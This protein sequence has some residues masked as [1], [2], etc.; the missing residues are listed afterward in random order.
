MANIS[1]PR[2]NNRITVIAGVSSVDGITPTLIYVDP[3]THR[4]LVDNSGTGGGVT[5][6]AAFGE[7]PIT[8]AVTIS[9]GTGITLNQV[10]QNVEINS[11]GGGGTPGGLD[12]QIQYNNAGSFGGALLSYNNSDPTSAIFYTSDGVGSDDGI[13][14]SLT[15]GNGGMTSGIGG[16]LS[17]Q[18]G[19]A[20]GGDSDGG[21]ISIVSGAKTGTG[22]EGSLYIESR[23]EFILNQ[24][25]GIFKLQNNGTFF[26]N[27]DTTNLI[28]D[29]NFAFPDQSGTLA[30]T[31]D[32]TGYVTS[33]S[34]TANRITSTGGTTP[35]IDIS[36][37]YIG[38]ASIT[39]LGTITTGVWQGTKIGLAFGGTNADLSATGGASQVLRQSSSGAAITVSQLAASDLS[40]GTTGSG[41]VVLAG[42]PTITTAVLGSSTA[43]TQTFGTNNTTLATTEFVQAA[44]TGTTVLAA[45][46]LATTAALPASTYSNGASGVGAT[47][48]EVG[49]G[50]LSIDGVTPSVG[51]RVLIKNQVSTFQNGIYTVT[52]VGSA[53]V[54]FVLTRSTDFDQSAEVNLGDTLF[55][56]AGSTLAGT[57]W[58]Q[59]GT[60]NPVMGTD[61]ITFAQTAGPGSYTAGN[62][63]TL[64]GTSFSID[65]SVTVD[66]NTVQTL[67]NKTIAAGSNTITGLTNANLSGT[68]GITN[69]N[70]ANS[71]ITIGSTN[72]ALGATSTT[73]AGLSSVTSTSFVGNLTGNADTIT[74]A[75]EATDTTCFIGFYTAA[76]G[77]LGGK[78]NALLTYNSN[79]NFF[80]IGATPDTVL[81]VASQT[82]I[83]TAVSGST[84]HFIGLDANPLRVTFDTHNN[85]SSSGTAFMFRRSRGTGGTPLAVSS[86]DVLASLNAR[87]YGTSQY[88]AASTGVLSWK[89]NQAFT[90]TA[91]GTYL[92]IDTT[93]DNSVTAGEVARFTG[94]GLTLGV[95]GTLGGILTLSG[96]STGTGIIQV[97]A[98][99]GAGIIFQIPSSN[100]SSGQF[101]QTNGS[102]VTSWQPVPGTILW[103]AVTVNASFT[104]NTGTLANKGTLLS[105]ALPTTSAVG[106]VV[107]IAGMNAGLWKIT[108]AAS[109]QIHF[110]NQNTTNGTGGS[111][112]SVL[113]Y[114]SI[115][116]VCSVANLEWV[117]INSVG[118]ITVT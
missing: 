78:T 7:T 22:D 66:K 113:T 14:Y 102:G 88:A 13:N 85:S 110:G 6:F 45:A 39:T 84:S 25:D 76:T 42:S 99:A 50:A 86:G 32:L 69:A 51:N 21:S 72:I 82:S 53:G 64:T 118:N 56:S 4:L 90:N 59:N 57:T 73:L 41:A 11:T 26:A 95:T 54:A 5:S 100:G 101:L 114:D 75:N 87:G 98:A 20:Q 2:D 48:T 77:S 97:A 116:L 49:L 109:Q 93:P 35:V 37:T 65:T 89:A 23:G 58:T 103:T 79:T 10:G 108:Q 3:I 94:T 80:G 40:N 29:Q 27:L 38:Q 67:T 104:V 28:A 34:G 33:V 115:Y 18:A 19:N 30:L 112:A 117:A 9:P 52:V 71:S 63:L 46:R 107:A 1:F 17:F 16:S 62:G 74:V 70:L 55:V 36:A 60:E 15:A 47:L 8:G 61:P 68:A 12:T 81:T 105:M 24:L 91:N 43:T 96:S 92:S 31:S 83:Q 44:I 111:L 106:D